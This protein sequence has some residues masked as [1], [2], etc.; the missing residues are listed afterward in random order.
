MCGP[1]CCYCCCCRTTTFL[2][3][4]GR[5]SQDLKDAAQLGPAGLAAVA[6]RGGG[7]GGGS[8]SG[9]AGAAAGWEE[10]QDALSGGPSRRTS[11]DAGPAGAAGGQAP[12]PEELAAVQAALAAQQAREVPEDERW[13]VQGTAA[14][15]YW[16]CPGTADLRVRGRNYLS[17]RKKVAAALPMFDLY[18]AELVEVD[19]PMWHMA[20]FLPS[21]K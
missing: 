14:R 7:G 11:F 4:S 20:R 17:D 5:R 18:S 1:L 9:A 2:T 10:Y 8:A 21:V 13:A 3:Y 15:R 12:S 19:E 16:S 6:E